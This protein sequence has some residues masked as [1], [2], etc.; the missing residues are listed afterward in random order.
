MLKIKDFMILV[1]KRLFLQQYNRDILL[2]CLT[3][4]L[5]AFRDNTYL[6]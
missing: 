1:R 6:P 2:K 5:K 4:Y 3:A